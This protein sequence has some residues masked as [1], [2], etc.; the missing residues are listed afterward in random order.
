MENRCLDDVDFA[1]E[2]LGEVALRPGISVFMSIGRSGGLS[3]DG[4]ASERVR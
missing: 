3:R 2:G 4:D 1:V